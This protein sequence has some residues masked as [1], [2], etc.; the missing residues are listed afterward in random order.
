M[1]KCYYVNLGEGYVVFTY[2]SLNCSIDFKS[3]RKKKRLPERGKIKQP[4][5][6]FIKKNEIQTGIRLPIINT[7]C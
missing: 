5:P 3:W 7:R 6:S 4:K 1:A 2:Y